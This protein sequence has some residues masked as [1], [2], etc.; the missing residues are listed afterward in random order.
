MNDAFNDA[1]LRQNDIRLGERKQNANLMISRIEN[2]SMKT[3]GER[4]IERTT[5]ACRD[6]YAELAAI[7]PDEWS[8]KA[9]EV[10]KGRIEEKYKDSINSTDRYLASIDKKV[11]ELVAGMEIPKPEDDVIHYMKMKEIREALSGMTLLDKQVYY[12]KAIREGDD[13]STEAIES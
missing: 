7:N 4:A 5:N 2:Q 10:Q 6:M 3:E 1:M 12:N 8:I 13:I 11:T 9:L